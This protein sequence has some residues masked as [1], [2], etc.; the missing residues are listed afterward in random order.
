MTA[1]ARLVVAH[2]RPV[3]ATWLAAVTALAA[4][5]LGVAD[6][7]RRSSL[8]IPGTGSS[9]A[10]ELA[11]EH[12]GD[13]ARLIVLLRG[14]PAALDRQGRRLAATLERRASVSVLAPWTAGSG[15]A[16]RP[17]TGEALLLVRS[18]RTFERVS[19]EVVPSV[20]RDVRRVIGP[21]L[22]AHVSGYADLAAGI[23]GDTVAAIRRAELIAAPAVVLVLLLVYRSPLAAA[24]PLLMGLATIAGGGGVLG[25]INRIQPLDAA[26]LTLATMMGLALGVDYSL[27]LVSRFR[28]ELAAGRD[29]REGAL[30]AVATAGRTVIFAGA[31]LAAAMATALVIAPGDLLTSASVGVIVAVLLSVAAAL[32]A[33]PATLAMLGHRID[34]WSFRA[35]RSAGSGV[36]G[37]A[38]RALRRPAIAAGLVVALVAGLAAPALA[39]PGVHGVYTMDD[40][41]PH[42]ANERLVVG[43][44]SAAY[45]QDI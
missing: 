32:G 36:G 43:M 15:R 42:L 16:L 24:L 45:K 1:L 3:V 17:N 6:R 22:E 12:F 4:L 20:R 19:R 21:P 13:S 26:A 44:P 31:A 25:L 30:V 18:Q 2:P 35:R 28:E 27:L 38:V 7:L 8:E 29:A 14:P 23:H 39:L 33:L 40:L 41:R 34:R 5:G 10:L 37:L 11:R 9:D